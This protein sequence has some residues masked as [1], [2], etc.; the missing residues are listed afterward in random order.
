[1]VH[2]NIEELVINMVNNIQTNNDDVVH[3]DVI[4]SGGAFNA[5]YLVGCLHFLREAIG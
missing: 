3:M 2:T 5:I 4:L 1:M